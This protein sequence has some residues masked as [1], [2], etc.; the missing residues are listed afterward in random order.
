MAKDRS[1]FQTDLAT[2]NYMVEN[3][4]FAIGD[5]RQQEAIAI[6]AANQGDYKHYPLV[7]CNS[8]TWKNAQISVADIQR[9]IKQ[10]IEATG[11]VYNDVKVLI[12]TNG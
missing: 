5:S 2:G 4:D 7:G 8:R 10:Q 11:L 6:I 9:T 3:G 12:E 1:D